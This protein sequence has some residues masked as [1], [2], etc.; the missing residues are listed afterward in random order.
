MLQIVLYITQIYFVLTRN[1]FAPRMGVLCQP[2]ISMMHQGFM[3]PTMVVAIMTLLGLTLLFSGLTLYRR[4]RVFTRE[5]EDRLRNGYSFT[6]ADY[7]ADVK[8]D[9]CFDDIGSETVSEC[10]CGK[11]YHLSC[12]EPTGEC[13]YCGAPFSDFKEPRPSRHIACPRCG[14]IMNGNICSCGTIIP[15]P[16]ETFLCRCGDRVSVNDAMCRRCGRTFGS[17]IHNVRK[18][19]IPN[20]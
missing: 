3:N 18:E 1:K 11:T 17:A 15:D 6:T 16:D 9:I 7:D 12:A 10:R 4:E 20:E 8:C 19:F 2:F 14:E 5:L 13:P